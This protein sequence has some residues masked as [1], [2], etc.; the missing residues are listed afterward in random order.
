[1]Y[2]DKDKQRAAVKRAV[3]RFRAKNNDSALSGCKDGS[4]NARGSSVRPEVGNTRPV[5]PSKCN[6]RDVIPDYQHQPHCNAPRH[7]KPF[8][9][10][11][12]CS[13][14]PVV[15]EQPKAQSYNPMMVGYVSPGRI[16]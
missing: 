12:C 14:R 11:V 15:I 13:C 9:K 8:T 3:R 16:A 10:G 7:A 5:I 4:K 1:M 2:K 6:T